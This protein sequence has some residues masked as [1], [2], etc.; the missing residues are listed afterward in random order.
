M[1]RNGTSD[2]AI[3]LKLQV[4]TGPSLPGETNIYLGDENKAF[5]LNTEEFIWLP[6]FFKTYKMKV[7]AGTH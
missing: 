3:Q 5:L 2:A 7:K 6:L 1:I 4:S